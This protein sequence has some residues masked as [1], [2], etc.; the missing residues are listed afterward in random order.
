MDQHFE[1]LLSASDP[2]QFMSAFRL[3]QQAYPSTDALLADL[4]SRLAPSLYEPWYDQDPHGFYGITCAALT[5]NLLPETKRW[6]PYAQQLWALRK[7][8]RRTP[9]TVDSPGPTSQATAEE[10]WAR[11]NDV[12]RSN[13]PAALGI[14]RTFLCNEADRDFFR[15]RTLMQALRD[16]ALGGHK[17]NYMAQ[18]WLVAERLGLKHAADALVG[19]LHLLAAADQ[20]FSALDE[21][22]EPAKGRTAMSNQRAA[23]PEGFSERVLY[24]TE[25]DALEALTELQKATQDG[26]QKIFD[27]LLF[28]AARTLAC[29]ARNRWLPAVRAF[30][31]TFLCQECYAWFDPQ[32]RASAVLQA[33]LIINRAARECRA[34]SKAP[35]LN[36]TIQVFC[37]TAPFDVLKSVISHS[38]PYAS[39]TAVYAILGMNEEARRELLQMLLAQALKNDGDMCWGHDILFV[40]ETWK[41]YTR[42]DS[43]NRDYFPASA[44]FLLGQILKKY[45]LAAEYGV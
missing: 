10:R 35:A 16:V 31:T 36:E 1:P 19:P 20:Q 42:S 32:D 8:R 45:T 25:R 27:H 18:S 44:G 15:A 12:T 14:C 22:V 13:F 7:Q 41:A 30:H 37:P 2:K 11:F 38:D 39:A 34:D 17:F 23:R 5:E 21:V 43:P 40:S 24:G 26:D 6:R 9:I 4:V 3:I 33:G 28:A 29:A